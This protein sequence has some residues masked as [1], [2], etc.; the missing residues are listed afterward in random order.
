MFNGT[1]GHVPIIHFP[2]SSSVE[3][4]HM[5]FP[6]VGM[7]KTGDKQAIKTMDARAGRKWAPFLNLAHEIGMLLV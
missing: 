7:Q 1:L 2:S 4:M 3:V 6:I 5:L